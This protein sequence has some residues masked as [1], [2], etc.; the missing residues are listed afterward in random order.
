M[1]NLTELA[2]AVGGTVKGAFVRLPGPG[3][4]SKDDSL[5]IWPTDR[6]PDGFE[7]QSFAGD[8]IEKCRTYVRQRI[9]ERGR[10][11]S[12]ANSKLKKPQLPAVRG[13]KVKRTIDSEF[14]YRQANGTPYLRVLKTKPKGFFQTQPVGNR[15]KNGKPKG[16]EIPYR[17]P[18]LIAASPEKPIFVCEGEKDA[19][20]LAAL[21]LIA[22]T[23]SGGAGKWG[24][25]LNCWFAGRLVYILPD[26]DEPGEHH[27]KKVA[28]NLR[29]VASEVRIVR[30]PDL[31]PKGDVSDFLKSGHSAD[32]LLNICETCSAEAKRS[33]AISAA[34]LQKLKLP[35]VK[36]IVPGFIVQG[37]TVFAGKPKSC[38]SWM[39]LDI[40]VA[41]ARGGSTL[42]VNCEAGDVFYGAF[43]DNE[44]RLQQRMCRLLGGGAKWPNRLTL[45][46]KMARLAQGGLEEL[47]AWVRRVNRPRLIIIDTFACVRDGKASR[48]QS[49]YDAD[50]EL[51]EGLKA[52]ANDHGIAVILVH[53]VRK[54]EAEDPLDT[55]SGTT[56]LTG[57]ADTVLVVARDSR[58][59]MLRGRGRDIEELDKAIEF[60][61]DTCR[62]KIIGSTEDVRRSDERKRILDAFE[63]GE[64]LTT[65]EIEART[66]IANNKLRMT[67]HRMV[68]AAELEKPKRGHYKRQGDNGYNG[69]NHSSQANVDMSACNNVTDV[70]AK[71][72]SQPVRP[73]LPRPPLP[74]Q[75]SSTNE[76]SRNCSRSPDPTGGAACPPEATRI[77]FDPRSGTR[78]PIAPFVSRVVGST[79]R[80]LA[81]KASTLGFGRWMTPCVDFI[82]FTTRFTV[83]VVALVI[84]LR[85]FL[86]AG[87]QIAS[88]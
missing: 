13:P 60:N 53:H 51:I 76:Q 86:C 30:L 17:L 87:P 47:E 23:N 19:D 26:N 2:A 70:T 33:L 29:Q 80:L 66:G 68:R 9:A 27:A 74:R 64:E 57:A 36:E 12:I 5:S 65:P 73:V 39:A 6:H 43:E 54:L 81:P 79:R 44:R 88:V 1:R 34:E 77:Y 32:D 11:G 67:L 42:G 58:G 55:V 63:D 10:S 82:G 35:T 59:S 38:K 24:S 45:Q 20:N 85:P 62:W 48:D 31:P 3:H 22:T 14:I 78:P 25:D 37:V 75:Q 21:G 18:E 49:A 4:S 8:P 50:Y 69:D 61:K 71:I 41:V 7:V 15:W 83:L 16:P 40:G 56:G 72:T 52:L 28:G 84:A 46:F